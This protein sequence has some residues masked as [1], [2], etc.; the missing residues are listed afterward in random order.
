LLDTANRALELEKGSLALS[1]LGK[2]IE[3]NPWRA[4]YYYLLALAHTRSQN[5]KAVGE[6]CRASLALNAHDLEV[7]QL[8]VQSLLQSNDPAAQAEFDTLMKY[9]PPTA[10]SLRAWFAGQNHR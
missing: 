7:R 2:L 8:L 9:N 3:A 1:A 4:D 6:S 5:W 10:N